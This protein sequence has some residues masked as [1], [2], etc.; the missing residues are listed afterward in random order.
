MNIADFYSRL[1]HANPLKRP[2]TSLREAMVSHVA[3]LH[4]SLFRSLRDPHCQLHYRAHGLTCS[5]SHNGS[6]DDQ[7]LA[8][9]RGSP[10]PTI[11][12]QEESFFR[13]AE[14]ALDE[15]FQD[16][17]TL[18]FFLLDMM[19]ASTLLA[20]WL[21]ANERDPEVRALPW[22]LSQLPLFLAAE[23]QAIVMTSRAVRWVRH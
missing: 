6:A 15:A 23:S 3:L 18:P 8:V 11:S 7:C 10:N 20:N 13:N 2:H 12:A 14:A 5:F 9:C 17:N 1:E 22:T 16:M 21:W 4:I 19:R